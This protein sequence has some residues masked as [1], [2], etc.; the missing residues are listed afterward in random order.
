MRERPAEIDRGATAAY[1]MIRLADALKAGDALM[2]SA[3]Q[4]Q[5]RE[6]GFDVRAR[7]GRRRQS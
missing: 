2:A 4:D 1:W 6:L 3:A 5:L 7:R